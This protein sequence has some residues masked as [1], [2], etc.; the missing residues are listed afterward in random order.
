MAAEIESKRPDAAI[1][2][3]GEQDAPGTFNVV[4]DGVELWNKHERGGFPKRAE[5]I[6]IIEKLP[7]PREEQSS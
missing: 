7:P 2:F 5:I 4:A 3:I 1:E 6:E